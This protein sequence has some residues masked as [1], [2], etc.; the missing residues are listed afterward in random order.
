MSFKQSLVRVGSKALLKTKQHA[1]EILMGLGLAAFGGGVA[2][3]VVGTIKATKVVEQ[4]KKL[5]EGLEATTIGSICEDGTEYTEEDKALDRKKIAAMTVG[6]MV[7]AYW[8]AFACV[9]TG[10]VCVLCANNIMHKRFASAMTALTTVTESFAAY[11]DRVAKKY[12][13]EEERKIRYGIEEDVQTT[14]I[15]DE[16]GNKVGEE[17]KVVE[18]ATAYSKWASPY[19]VVFDSKSSYYVN[20]AF[21]NRDCVKQVESAMTDRLNYN[22]F[23]T[24]REVKEALDI[25]SYSPIDLDAGWVVTNHGEA[26]GKSDPYVKI[27]TLTNDEIKYGDQ[28]TPGWSLNHDGDLLLDFNC[29]PDIRPYM[30]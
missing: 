28:N 26:D 14:D 29:I 7:R 30:A 21:L 12:G 15:L 18:K 20:N 8:P 17:T 23:L 27:F 9:A 6:G 1:P 22:G 5:L 11:R 4:K 16:N 25:P 3:T 24:L 19:A 2:F 13:V 10:T